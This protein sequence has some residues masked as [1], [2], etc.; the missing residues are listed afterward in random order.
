MRRRIPNPCGTQIIS[1]TSLLADATAVMMIAFP[2]TTGGNVTAEDWETK[3]TLFQ[4]EGRVNA[5]NCLSELLQPE[6]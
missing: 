6:K 3:R 4:L 1:F 5:R 2:R